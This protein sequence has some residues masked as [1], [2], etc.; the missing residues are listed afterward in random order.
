MT[1]LSLAI[2]RLFRAARASASSFSVTE[3]II[4]N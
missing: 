1:S 2:L 3:P 4:C